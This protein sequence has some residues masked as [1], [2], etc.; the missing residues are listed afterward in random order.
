[1]RRAS[2]RAPWGDRPPT[3]RGAGVLEEEGA[4]FR[5][6]GFWLADELGRA[7]LA[8]LDQLRAG[9][10][11]VT[12]LLFV[13]RVALAA[14]LAEDGDNLVGEIHLGSGEAGQNHGR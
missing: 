11:R 1:M 13:A 2:G 9:V 6:A 4:G 7:I 14:M 5:L 8:A 10:H 12:A 3:D